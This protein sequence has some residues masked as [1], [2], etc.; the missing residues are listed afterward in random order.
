MTDPVRSG[1]VLL[2]DD[3][4]HIRELCRMYLEHAGFEVLEAGDGPTALTQVE[5]HP[6][7]VMVLDLMLPE[8]DGFQVLAEVRRRETWLP[9]IML[10][11]LGDE[12]DRIMGLDQGADDYLIKPFSPRELVSRV[13]AVLRRAF[14]A[15][16]DEGKLLRHPGLI[17]DVAQRRV[18][19]GDEVLNL[20]PR[21]FDLLY[22]LASH[23]KQVFS[24][25]HLL[26]RVWGLDFDGDSRTVDVHVTRLRQKLLAS[27]TPYEY[28]ETVW[29]QGYRF[30]VKARSA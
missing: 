28:L 27:H 23:P 8:M 11:A 6:V 9:V 21:E 22:F 7:D 13:R 14:L 2:V 30:V 15:P 5:Q 20:T 19:A 17:V 18:Q 29:G 24:R 1:R 26:D 10:T 4:A 12:E 25:E 3:D 16:A